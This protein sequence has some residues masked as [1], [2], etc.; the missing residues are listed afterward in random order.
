MTKMHEDELDVDETLVR[1]LLSSQHPEWARLSLTPIRSSGSDHALFRLGDDYVIRLPR[2]GWAT[3]GINKEYEWVPK[4]AQNLTI[5]VSKP[6]FKGQPESYYPHFWIVHAWN[7][8]HNPEFEQNDEYLELVK[9]LAAFLNEFHDIKLI[10]GPA[11]RRGVPLK[12]LS[13]ETLTSLNQLDDEVDKNY[14]TELWNYLVCIPNWERAPVWV[15]GD[16][17]PGNILVENNHLT[18]VIDFSDVGIGDPA[19]D[20]VIAWSLLNKKSRE[21]FKNYLKNIDENTWERGRG[22]A[23]SIALIMLPYYMDT[24]PY[25]A[26]LAKRMIKAVS[27]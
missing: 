16:F 27:E 23:L 14:F 4:I 26:L 12:N 20:L 15:H 24:N 10:G 8:G 25:Y 9:E 11:S 2:V 6:I 1:K 3:Q 18:A 21:V 5:P 13:E 22:W 17:L 7:D 19:C